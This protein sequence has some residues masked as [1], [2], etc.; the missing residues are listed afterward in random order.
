MVEKPLTDLDKLPQ[1]HLEEDKDGFDLGFWVHYLLQAE[2]FFARISRYLRKVPTKSIPTAGVSLNP[3]SINFEIYY[4]PEFFGKLTRVQRKWVLMHEMYHIALGHVTTRRPVDVPMQKANI[5]MD[6]AINSLPSMIADAPDFCILP[7]RE[8]PADAPA[9]SIAHLVANHLPGQAM[10]YYLNL[11]P[12]DVGDANSF[13]EHGM[14]DMSGLSDED[15]DALREIAAHKIKEIIQKAADESDKESIEGG[16]GWGT[17]S[18][19]M[20]RLIKENL[21]VKLDPKKI[22]A[23]FCKTSIRAERRHS[24]TKINRRYPYIHAGRRFTRRARI[25]ISID[26]SGS[27]SDL[28]LE[29]FFGWLN[30]LCKFV[31]FVVVPFDH[32]VFEDKIY[33]WK[34][35]QKRITERVLMGGT[36][37]DAPTTYVNENSKFDAHVVMTDMAAP[38]PSKSLVPRIWI[39]DKANAANPYMK[40][41]ERVLVVD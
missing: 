8:A 39:T 20:K 37:F 22:F 28:L 10:E 4:N 25:A 35:G 9:G 19:E 5:G 15:A 6:E 24:M 2:P 36:N 31:E 23:Y 11:L 34:K 18:A 14:W 40:N 17:V 29:K 16:Q 26:Q 7:G 13:D 21:Q 3:H 27:V 38:A 32:E 12:N 30:E 1:L 33:T 41:G